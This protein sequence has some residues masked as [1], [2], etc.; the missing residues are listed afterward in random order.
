M[1]K[2]VIEKKRGRPPKTA[3][4]YKE[5]IT[6]TIKNTEKDFKKYSLISN[7]IIN[8]TINTNTKNIIVH[9]FFIQNYHIEY[10][11]PNFM[12]IDLINLSQSIK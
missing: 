3:T 4:Q 6:T 5:P 2:P 7:N 11:I 9:F 12:R 8:T 10:Y 1:N